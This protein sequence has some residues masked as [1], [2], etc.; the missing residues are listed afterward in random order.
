MKKNKSHYK[1]SNNENDINNYKSQY[2]HSHNDNDINNGNV[3]K[4]CINISH[5]YK[6]RNYYDKDDE[7]NRIY[8]YDNSRRIFYKKIENGGNSKKS[9]H[10]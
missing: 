2:K 10:K 6:K 5:K 4:S 1:H 8:P 7:N 9:S 3:N